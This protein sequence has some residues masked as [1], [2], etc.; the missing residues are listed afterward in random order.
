MNYFSGDLL[1]FYC[2]IIIGYLSSLF[3]LLLLFSTDCKI[4]DLNNFKTYLL[5]MIL[6]LLFIIFI[7][8][9]GIFAFYFQNV[10]FEF[11]QI[12]MDSVPLQLLLQS[13]CY[14]VFLPPLLLLFNNVLNIF[15]L[16]KRLFFII[17]IN[18]VKNVLILIVA[19]NIRT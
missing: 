12:L 14:F 15:V 1:L 5:F 7:Y 8:L 6:Y 16:L 18:I 2:F 13:P 9:L 11:F 19:L 4:Y 10:I 17:F 3:A